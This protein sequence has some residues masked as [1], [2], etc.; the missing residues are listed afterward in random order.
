M[1]SLL[2]DY[3]VFYLDKQRKR[4]KG[5]EKLRQ[6]KFS[7][8]SPT[9]MLVGWWKVVEHGTFTERTV[10]RSSRREQQNG[11]QNYFDDC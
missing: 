8:P 5:K 2:P 4:E 6:S 11:K 9:T 7:L 1:L 10:V 3:W